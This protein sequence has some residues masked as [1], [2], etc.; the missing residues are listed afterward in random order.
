MQRA[1]HP[2]VC[3]LRYSFQNNRNLYLVMDFMPGGKNIT[4]FS[5]TPGELFMHLR[6][7]KKF[8]EGTARFYASE[9]ILA[10][11]YLH[12]G[13]DVVYRYINQILRDPKAAAEISNL[14]ISCWIVMDI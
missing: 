3:N 11:E 4:V 9:V 8:E 12:E 1:S 7:M 2:F 6:R 13:L 14:K 10:L 5:K